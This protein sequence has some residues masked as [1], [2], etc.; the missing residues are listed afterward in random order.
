MSVAASC[1]IPDADVRDL[2]HG[3][4]QP[5]HRGRGQHRHRTDVKPVDPDLMATLA[6]QIGLD[7]I[8]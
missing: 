3:H 2:R 7:G 5:A 8:R 1:G 6:R 4:L